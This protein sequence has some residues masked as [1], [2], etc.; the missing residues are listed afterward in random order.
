M[1]A[2][3]SPFAWRGVTLAIDTSEADRLAKLSHGPV[4]RH[5]PLSLVI[6]SLTSLA[7]LCTLLSG[8]LSHSV[9]LAS[10]RRS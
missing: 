7:A 5:I 8:A 9:L 4:L 2:A 6:N 1:R 10:A 3:C